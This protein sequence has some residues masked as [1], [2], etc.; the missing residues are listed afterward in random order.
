MFEVHAGNA[1]DYLRR[2]RRV[3]GDE[4]IEA[5]ELAGGVS[6]IVLLITLPSRG[7][8]FVLKQARGQLRVKDDWRCPVE[9]IWREVETLRACSQLIKTQAGAEGHDVLAVVPEILWEDREN[10]LYAMTAA[11]GGHQTWRELLFTVPDDI[12]LQ[13][14]RAS[15]ALLAAIHADS[16]RSPTMAVPFDDR[17]YFD[18]L[19]LDPYYRQIARVHADRADAIE[20]LI[21]SGE[22]NRLSLVH[23]DFSPKNLLVWPG[24]MML[25]DYEVGHYG[26]PAFDLGFFFTHL[27]LKSIWSGERRAEYLTIL[28]EF[29]REYRLRLSQAVESHELAALEQRAVLNLAGCMLARV[30]GK[31]P[32]DYL[33]ADQQAMVR[34][35][36]RRWLV[37]P[38]AS[39][40]AAADLVLSTQY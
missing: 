21:R 31:S 17:T 16:W 8:E 33:S 6:N 35:L 3:G 12:H 34:H 38:P 26:D 22:V 20:R 30:D 15:A 18:Q 7:E 36:S 23:G 1:A 9:R 25:I 2:S 14:A 37:Q 32:V 5:R 28:R 29:W 27:V 10:Y 4:A 39:I 24:H 19:R 40:E 13:L 11:P